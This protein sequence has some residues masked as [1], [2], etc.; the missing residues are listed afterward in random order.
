MQQNQQNFNDVEDFY[1]YIYDEEDTSNQGV[2]N[3]KKGNKNFGYGRQI[4]TRVLG[5][6]CFNAGIG[7]REIQKLNP[8]SIILTSGTLSPLTSFQ[9]ELQVDFKWKLE[10]PHVIS[11]EQVSISIL[12]KGVNG[13]SFNFKF[14]NRENEHAI[15]DLGFS[16][17]KI[18]QDTPGGVLIFFA[19]YSY[20]EKCHE[21]WEYKGIIKEMESVKKVLKEPKDS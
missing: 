17:L 8:K 10:N 20:M 21:L 4:T 13:N 12:S 9:Q 11:P 19:S 6:W 3:Y 16:I 18:V 15:F 2:F 5:F 7:F 1:V 14:G